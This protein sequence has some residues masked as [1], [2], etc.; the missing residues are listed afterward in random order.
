MAEGT[1]R[2]CAVKMT[3][4]E[5]VKISC[6]RWKKQSCEVE[7]RAGETKKSVSRERF[8][9]VRCSCVPHARRE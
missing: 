9:P 1:D 8:S 7:I 4:A 2:Q 6:G 3:D 5:C